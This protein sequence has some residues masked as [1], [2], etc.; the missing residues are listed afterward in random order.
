MMSFTTVDVPGSSGSAVFG[1]NDRGDLCG[2]YSD[3]VGV[4]YAYVALKR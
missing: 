1:I 3:A 4:S 2:Y